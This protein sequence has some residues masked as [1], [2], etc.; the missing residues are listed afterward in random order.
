MD[1]N[2]SIINVV[3]KQL[4]DI[5]QEIQFS[6]SKNTNGYFK[7]KGLVSFSR[8]KYQNGEMLILSKD[9][10]RFIT[11]EKPKIFEFIFWN[12]GVYQVTSIDNS[13]KG[14]Y[15]NICEYIEEYKN[16][17]DYTLSLA[18]S[19]SGNL[20]VG[21]TMQLKVNLRKD[22]EVVT[23]LTPYKFLWTTS[24]KEVAIVDENGLVTGVSK[25]STNI[26]CTMEQDKNISA[27]YT[28]SVTEEEVI[29]T[30]NGDK[31]ISETGTTYKYS[32]SDGRTTVN[33]D[34]I[35]SIGNVNEDFLLN[36]SGGILSIMPYYSIKCELTIIAKSEITGEELLR[37][38]I[39]VNTIGEVTFKITNNITDKYIGDSFKISSELKVNG[40]VKTSVLTYKSSDTSVAT[41]DTKGTVSCDSP[42]TVTI[43]ATCKEYDVSDSITFEVGF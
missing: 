16:N 12:G 14:I 37:D 38:T 28:I 19:D 43:T 25:G 13:V 21:D 32:L 30:L 33:Y 31:T 5:G 29:L 34:V 17:S 40:T 26:T 7:C 22:E 3:K 15:K 20:K 11:L 8:Q 35:S 10:Y 6:H 24:N 2:Q 1:N 36:E 39:V 41:V 42:G 4:T 18:P 9:I 23:D 27:D